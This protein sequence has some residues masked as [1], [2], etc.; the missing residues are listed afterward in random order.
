M[1]AVV[2]PEVV[3]EIFRVVGLIDGLE[4]YVE[5]AQETGVA[6]SGLEPLSLADAAVVFIDDL[7]RDFV[8]QADNHGLGRARGLLDSHRV[9]EGRQ[10]LI[11]VEYGND[12][13]A[14]FFDVIQN[15][16]VALVHRLLLQNFLS[17]I[18]SVSTPE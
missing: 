12:V 15:L 5:S 4:K 16:A 8:L 17:A 7:T 14:E 11:G 2:Q 18:I 3:S 13:T 1:G 10:C 9:G 6:F